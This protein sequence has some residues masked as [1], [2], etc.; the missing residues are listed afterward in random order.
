MTFSGSSWG[1][2]GLIALVS[3]LASCDLFAGPDNA[4]LP[5]KSEDTSKPNTGSTGKVGPSIK[6]RLPLDD[7]G[8]GGYAPDLILGEDTPLFASGNEPFWTAEIGKGWIV[9]E[10][11]G[12]PLVEVPVPEFDDTGDQI[13]FTSQ[14]LSLELTR[15]GCEGDSGTL[16]V[17]IKF[18]AVEHEGETEEISYHGCAGST[19]K[20]KSSGTSTISWKD[21]VQPSL[22][23]IDAC[24]TTAGSDQLI[25]ALYPREPGTVGMILGDKVGSYSECGAD[26]ETGEVYFLDPMSGEQA[27]EWMNGAAF[28]RKGQNLACRAGVPI[29]G[30]VGEYLPDGC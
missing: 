26:T 7:L 27:A 17:V 21:L 5:V 19:G 28:I 10:R 13:T 20:I 12:L 6:D 18:E 24:L 23:A 1:R 15:A 2:G 11:P 9:F 30:D 8:K 14:G 3:L 4:D 25:V 29:N 22:T 16:G